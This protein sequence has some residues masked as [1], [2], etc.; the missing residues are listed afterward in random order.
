MVLSKY[1]GVPRVDLYREAVE[2]WSGEIILY[3]EKG[4][5]KKAD[6]RE[7]PAPVEITGKKEKK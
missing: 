2:Q 7:N 1:A 4:E 5:L 3:F 6:K